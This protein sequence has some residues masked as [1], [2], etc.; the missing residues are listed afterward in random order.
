MFKLQHIHT[1]E[2]YDGVYI[3]NLYTCECYDAV[4]IHTCE[5]YDGVYIEKIYTSMFEVI[6]TLG[7]YS[8]A[9]D[10]ISPPTTL[11]NYILDTDSYTKYGCRSWPD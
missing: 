2:C 6:S 4:Y 9:R 3:E 10:E 7:T 11:T 1:C 8:P 5:C